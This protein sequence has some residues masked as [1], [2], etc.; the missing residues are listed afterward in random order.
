LLLGSKVQISAAVA[1]TKTKRIKRDN[2]VS[3]QSVSTVRRR[4][5][6]SGLP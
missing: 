5:T 4:R 6:V 2:T 1:K 3:E